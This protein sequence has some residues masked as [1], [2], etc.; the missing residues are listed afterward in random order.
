MHLVMQQRG[1]LQR[2]VWF[3]A[4]AGHEI[5][6]IGI[7]LFIKS[8]AHLKNALWLHLGA[9]LGALTDARLTVRASCEND[10]TALSQ[11]LLAA[12]YERSQLETAMTNHCVGE[13]RDIVESGAKVI[14]MVARNKYFH[15][16]DDRLPHAVSM[17]NIKAICRAS[18]EFL[19]TLCLQPQLSQ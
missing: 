15:S 11:A 3:V 1:Q 14:S 5:G 12:G 19:P 8:H 17:H 9:N 4:T 6:H 16:P 2:D 10:A 13:A 7:D 18:L